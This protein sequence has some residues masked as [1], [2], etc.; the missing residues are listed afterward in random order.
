VTLLASNIVAMLDAAL[1]LGPQSES[2]RLR[3]APIG[4]MPRPWPDDCTLAVQALTAWQHEGGE[5][6]R[7]VMVQLRDLVGRGA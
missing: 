7:A 1:T 2:V 6:W 5:R 3:M 4:T